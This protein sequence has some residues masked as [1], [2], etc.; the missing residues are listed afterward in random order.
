VSKAIRKY[1]QTGALPAI[2]TLCEADLKPLFGSRGKVEGQGLSCADQK[3][4][5]AVMAEVEQGYHPQF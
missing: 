1:F 5:D 2:G 4:M 3:L